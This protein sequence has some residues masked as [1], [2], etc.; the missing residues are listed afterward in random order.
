MA[1]LDKQK[2]FNNIVSSSSNEDPTLFMK[3]SGEYEYIFKDNSH[4]KQMSPTWTAMPVI[5]KKSK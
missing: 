2:H 1:I 4:Q 3:K 5:N